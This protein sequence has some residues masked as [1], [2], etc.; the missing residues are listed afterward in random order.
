M[1]LP[2]FLEY[3]DYGFIRLTGHRIGLAH[4]VREYNRGSSAEMICAQ[5]PTLSLS[6]IYKVMAFYLDNQAEVDAYVAADDAALRTME[7]ESRKTSRMPSLEEL[8]RRL[9]QMQSSAS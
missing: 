7:E 4:V 2:S 3:E 5:F 9:A 1:T 8:R 6:T